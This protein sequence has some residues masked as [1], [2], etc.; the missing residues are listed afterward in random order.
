MYSLFIQ[1]GIDFHIGPHPEVG[2]TPVYLTKLTNKFCNCCCSN[3][4]LFESVQ[5]AYSFVQT[6]VD[7]APVTTLDTLL[8][9]LLN[10]INVATIVK[11]TPSGCTLMDHNTCIT[12]IATVLTA[13]SSCLVDGRNGLHLQHFL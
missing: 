3:I 11:G 10:L 4:N 13:T 5:I 9:T 6:G 7:F 2:F 8:G 12:C 1:F